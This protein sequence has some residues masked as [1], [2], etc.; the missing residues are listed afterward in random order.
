[1]AYKLTRW[2]NLLLSMVV[3]QL[4]RW[5]PKKSRQLLMKIAA[6]HLG[7][8]YAVEKHFNPDYNPW[9]QRLCVVP[10]ADLFEVIRRGEAAV[11]TDHIDHFTPKGIHLRSGR[12]LEADIVVL[13]TGL[14]IK[15]LGGVNLEVDGKPVQ[16]KDL[17]AYKG[18]MMSNVP[19]LAVAF[20]YTNASWTLKTD[21]TANYF[22]KLLRYMDRRDH[23]IVVPCL[24]ESVKPEPFLN[25]TSG[26]FKRAG[27]ILP[28]Q[29]ASSPWRVYQNYFLDTLLIRYGRIADGVL[30]FGAKGQ[31]PCN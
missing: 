30:K 10:N 11:V 23:A 28:K 25:L 8:D 27:E 2:K 13:A 26:Y 19:N 22:C 1:M 18:M 9:D 15:L 21:L 4:T 16:T 14:K 3:Y 5:F 6:R 20:G 17:M 24:D 31:L 12:T 29:G 7:P